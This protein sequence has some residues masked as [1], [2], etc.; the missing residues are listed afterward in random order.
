MIKR[1]RG[2]IVNVGFVVSV[3][4]KVDCDN[5]RVEKEFS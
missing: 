1:F 3:I 5:L 4:G 2:W